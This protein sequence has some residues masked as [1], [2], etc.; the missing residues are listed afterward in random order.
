VAA[1]E[2]SESIVD[3]TLFASS[4]TPQVWTHPKRI[5]PAGDISP[6]AALSFLSRKLSFHQL[7]MNRKKPLRSRQTRSTQRKR[8][9][10]NAKKH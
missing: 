7:N 8:I 2:L 6:D 4:E 5:P 9:L 1:T 3:D 10:L